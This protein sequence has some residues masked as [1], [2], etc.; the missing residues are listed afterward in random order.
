MVYFKAS[1][2]EMLR[3][4]QYPTGTID[5]LHGIP[6]WMKH[7]KMKKS[8][9]HVP[10]G[11]MRAAHTWDGKILLWSFMESSLIFLLDTDWGGMT[12]PFFRWNKKT[13]ESVPIG[14]GPKALNCFNKEMFAIDVW[15]LMRAPRR[16]FCALEL[17]GQETKQTARFGDCMVDILQTNAFVTWQAIYGNDRRD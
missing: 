5:A 6:V 1:I 2:N 10:K 9:A 8:T 11:T 3:L 16:A 17:V 15:D 13:G 14:H 4:N 12:E 7:G